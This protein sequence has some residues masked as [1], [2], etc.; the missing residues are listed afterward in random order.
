MSAFLGP[1]HYWLYNKIV[2]FEELEKSLVDNYK[3]KYGEVSQIVFKKYC[4]QYD[5]PIQPNQPLENIIDQ[6]DIHGWLQE[7]ISTAETRQAAFLN[8]IF[9]TYGSEAIE[10]ALNVYAAQGKEVGARSQASQAPSSAPELFKE[11]N[12]FIL[13][14]MPCDRV[15]EFIVSEEDHL[16]WRTVSC[17]H[18]GYWQSVGADPDIFYNLRKQWI[19][20]F[21]ENANPNYKYEFEKTSDSLSHK[22]IK[23]GN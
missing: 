19:T 8:E 5:D 12:N 4:T 11:L 2:L 6:S 3:E 15:N 9:N 20:A 22:I 13:D 23:G 7:K 17:L 16:E 1:I 10:L 21:V 14:G 18:I